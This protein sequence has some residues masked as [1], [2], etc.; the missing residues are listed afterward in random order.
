MKDIASMRK[1]RPLEPLG[2]GG[3]GTA[4]FAAFTG[5]AALETV[6]DFGVFFVEGKR[7]FYQDGRIEVRRS[8]KSTIDHG[9]TQMTGIR[10]PLIR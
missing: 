6:G 1:M 7:R 10:S 3:V 4:D 8:W 9:F 2:S 5:L